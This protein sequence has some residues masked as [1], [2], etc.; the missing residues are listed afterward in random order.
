MELREGRVSTFL[1]M[2][3]SDIHNKHVWKLASYFKTYFFFSDELMQ[4][5]LEAGIEGIR[6]Y[7]AE[8]F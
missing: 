5:L 6:S 8:D 4:L 7:H 1:S 3:K 2:K